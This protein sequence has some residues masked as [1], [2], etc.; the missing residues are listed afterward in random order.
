MNTLKGLLAITF[1]FFASIETQAQK[2]SAEPQS[3]VKINRAIE[4]H[5]YNNP[6]T[7]A[8]LLKKQEMES[9]T[10]KIVVTQSQFEEL[11]RVGK[12]PTE[13]DRNRYYVVDKLESILKE[14]N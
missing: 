12:V 7:E 3:T 9:Q 2:N 10:G 13:A 1:I 6:N 4:K 8:I 5:D 14:N 11:E